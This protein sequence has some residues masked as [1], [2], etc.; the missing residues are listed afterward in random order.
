MLTLTCC[1]DHILTEIFGL[2]GLQH[3]V[4][5]IRR[6]VTMRDGQTNDDD[7]EQVKLE[8]L[9]QW[10]LYEILGGKKILLPA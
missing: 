8:L 2:Y 10:K 3:H 5:E 9:S 7:D 1:Q 6:D 4:V